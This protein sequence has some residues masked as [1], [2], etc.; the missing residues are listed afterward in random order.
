M[1]SKP[2]LMHLLVIDYHRVKIT[3]DIIKIME[4]FTKMEMRILG[5]HKYHLMNNILLS[6]AKN[7]YKSG[8]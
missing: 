2:Y 3:L 4:Y 6:A 7:I 5:Q 1:N 8:I